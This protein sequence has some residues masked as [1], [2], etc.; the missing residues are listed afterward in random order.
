MTDKEQ[1]KELQKK[2]ASEGVEYCYAT[3]VDVHGVS[4]TKCVPISHLAHMIGGSEL[5]TVGAL[6]GM[7]LVGP[8]FDECAAVPDLASA[9]ILPWDRRYCWFASDLHFHGEPYE[10]CSRVILKK[11]AAKAAQK[12]LVFNLGI[13][14]EFYVLRRSADGLAPFQTETFHG[15]TPAY[16]LHQI[17]LAGPFL[18]EL[19]RYVEELGWG[20]Y[21]FDQEGGHGQFEIDFGYA[22]VL[23]TA[24]RLTFFRF[25]VKSIARKHGA[26]ASFMPKPFSNDFRSGAHHNMS[27]MDTASKENIFDASVRPVGDLARNYGLGATDDTLHFAGGL[28]E[29]AQALCA[30][31]CPS[32]NSYK[33]LIAQGDMPDMSWAPVLQAYGRNNRSAMLRLPMNRPC[34]ENRA[35]DM[36][37]NFYLSSAFSLYAGLDGLERKV[38][39]GQPLNDNLYLARDIRSQGRNVRRLPRTL[40]EASDALDESSFARSVLGEEF[41]DIY[42]AQKRKEWDAQFY[43]VTPVERDK[44]LTFV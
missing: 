41:I 7:G 35:P 38:D 6:E 21:S 33:G 14:P 3:Y 9:T 37:A 42:V 17:S 25:M 19:T 15:P 23:T 22:D 26:V 30:F 40:L 2:L 31:T 27:L 34:I 24:D 43:T 18:E 29:H 11:A 16:D 13:E 28:L 20:L 10:N 4:K 36:S 5:F 39:P 12:N 1:A 32:Y 8:H 44:Y